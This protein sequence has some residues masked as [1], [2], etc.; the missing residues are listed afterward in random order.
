MHFAWL[1][2]LERLV[3]G[4]AQTLCILIS[5]MFDKVSHNEL[6]LT[7]VVAQK[8]EQLMDCSFNG[9]GMLSSELT[10]RESLLLMFQGNIILIFL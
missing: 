10:R 8:V 3:K 7:E 1:V 6:V 9:R 2:L 5:A 4:A